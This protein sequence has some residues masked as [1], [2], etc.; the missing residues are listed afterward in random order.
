MPVRCSPACV[1]AGRCAGSVLF[2][3]CGQ[4][5]AAAAA[6]VGSAAWGESCVWGG[7]LGSASDAAQ[8]RAAVLVGCG[9]GEARCL[10]GLGPA[11]AH[12][13]SAAFQLCAVHQFSCLLPARA[14]PWGGHWL[15][16]QQACACAAHSSW[17]GR[18][19]CDGQGGE[20]CLGTL[21]LFAHESGA[22]CRMS[23]GMR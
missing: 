9:L 5:S 12:P 10:L 6:V 15:Q 3:G 17:L 22:P 19:G 11:S 20:V 21:W 8:V 4:C 2:G 23:V 7:L 13:C 1:Q 16:F 14:E 18:C